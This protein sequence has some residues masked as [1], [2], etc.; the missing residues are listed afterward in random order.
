MFMLLGLVLG[1]C[2]KKKGGGGRKSKTP[3]KSYDPWNGVRPSLPENPV[4]GL[5]LLGFSDGVAISYDEREASGEEEICRRET[6]D[7]EMLEVCIP[8]EDDPY[9]V[10]LE[11][12]AFVWH[13]LMFERFATDLSCYAYGE[14]EARSEEDCLLVVFP[15]MGGEDFSCEAG[16]VNGDRALKCS[17]DWAV[18]ANGHESD[19]KSICRAHLQTGVGICL[20]APK[21]GFSDGELILQMQRSNWDGYR[22]G[23]D[24]N[25]QFMAGDS[26]QALIPQE[27]PGGA[28]VSY[29][30]DNDEICTVDNDDEDGGKGSV[31]IDASVTPPEVCKIYLLIEA[32]GFADWVLFVELPILDESDVQWPN[33]VRSNNYFYPG[34]SLDAEPV[35]STAT[36]DLENE[37]ISL[38]EG[39]CSVDEN[40]TIT[41]LAPG[42]CV[43]RLTVKAQ[44][45]LDVVID[46]TTPVDALT[47][48]IIDIVWDSFDALDAATAV[49]GADIPALTVPVAKE[50]GGVDASGATLSYDVSGGCAYD[51]STRILSFSDVTECVITVTA[52]SGVRSEADFSKDFAFTPGPALFTLTWAG[53]AGGNSAQY[54][55]A[56]PALEPPVTDPVSL[57][58]EYSYTASGGGC[59]VDGVSGALTIVGATTCEVTLTASKE[60]YGD[61]TQSHT[62]TIDKKA[63]AD[64]TFNAPYAGALNVAVGSTPVRVL[65]PPTG[66]VGNLE[67]KTLNT[68]DCDIESDGTVSATAAATAGN[69]CDIQARWSGDANHDESSWVT[70]ATITISSADQDQ[71]TWGA[72]PY[73][74]IPVVEVDDDLDINSAPS[75]S[76]GDPAYRSDTPGICTVDPVSGTVT[77]VIVGECLV[78][79]RFTGNTANAASPWS[80][81]ITIPVDPGVH[82]ALS[83]SNYY[84]DNPEVAIARNLALTTTPEGHGVAT[85]SVKNGSETYCSVEASSGT[86][87]GLALGSCTIQVSFA[88]STN[89]NAS[90]AMD[91]GTINVLEREQTITINNPYGTSATMAVEET[92]ELVNAPTAVIQDNNGNSIEGGAIT[93]QV[94]TASAG[95]CSVA[96][97]GVITALAPGECAIQ[98]EVAAVTADANKPTY[99][100]ATRDLA[101]IAVEMGTFSFTWSPQLPGVDYRTGMESKIARVDIGSTGAQV[102]YAVVDAG[103]TGCDFKGN[104]GED[105]VTLSF[106]GYGVCTLSATA[107]KQHYEDWSMERIIRVRPG[108]I[109]ATPGAFV[110]SDTL[111]VGVTQPKVP[112][113][114]TGL[115]PSDAEASWQLVRGEKDCVLVNEQTGAVVAR[116]VPIPD[117]ANPPQCS[118]QVVASKE[119]YD[120]FKSEPVSIDL[121]RGDMGSLTAPEYGLGV[122]ATL[123]ING[124]VAIFK[125][126]AE[127][128]GLPVVPIAFAATGTQSD[129]TTDKSDVCDVQSDG[130]V[131]AGS[132]AAAGDQCKIVITMEAPGYEPA[133]APEAVLTVVDG[134]FAFETAPVVSFVG[135]LK[136]G[137]ET[138]ASDSGDSSGV[139]YLDLSGIPEEYVPTDDEGNPQTAVPLTWHYRARSLDAHGDEDE[140]SLCEIEA[141]NGKIHLDVESSARVGGHCLVKAIAQVSGYAEYAT[142]ELAIPFAP[143]DLVIT[144][145]DLYAGATLRVG[146]VAAASDETDDDNGVSVTWGSWRAVGTDSGSAEK[147]DV[148]SVDGEGLVQAGSAAAA[149]DVCTVY[150][151][152]GAN[153]YNNS[154]ELEVGSLTLVARMALG[155]VTGPVYNKDL[156]VRGV[157]VEFD[158]APRISGA[159]ADE[160]IHWTYEATGKRAG[161]ATADICSVDEEGAVLPGSDATGGDTC[162]IVATA[163][164]PGYESKAA[165]V[166]SL[167]VKDTFTSLTW[168]NFPTEGVVGTDIN[169]ADNQPVSDPVGALAIS[170]TSDDCDYNSGS[171]VLSFSDASECVVEV[172]AS[173][174]GYVD[175]TETY[176]VTPSSGSIAVSDW[177]TYTGVKVGV[178]IAAPGLTN[179]NPS[180]AEKS[181]ALAGGSAGCT[182]DSA[183]AV[184]GTTVGS[185]A[186]QVILTL[187]NTGY[188]NLEHTYSI[189]V[190]KGD[191]D[192]PSFAADPYGASPNVEPD[193]TLALNVSKPSGQGTLEFSVKSS[194][195]GNCTVDATSGEISGADA[196]AGS[197]CTI[198]AQFLTN[199]DYNAS[200]L[201]DV[202]TV[203]VNKHD[204]TFPA[205][206]NPYGASPEVA[207]GETETISAALPS[208]QGAL[209][210]QILSGHATYCSVDLTS[211]EVTPKAAG[212][213][214][215][216]SVQARFVGNSAHEATAWSTIA[217]ISVINGTITAS[218]S[219]YGTVKVAA[220]TSAPGVTS[221]PVGAARAWSL[222]SGS[223]G[224]TLGS[225][226]AVTGDAV[227]TD[228]CKVK[229]IL[230]ENGYDNLEHVYTFSIAKGDQ[231][232]VSAVQISGWSNPY[233]TSLELRT[234]GSH[235]LPA[236]TG[237]NSGI[238][239]LGGATLEYQKKPSSVSDCTVAQDGTVTAGTSEGSCIV[240][241]R[242]RES[243]Q[244]NASPNWQDLE[245]I[246][247]AAQ[248][249]TTTPAWSGLFAVI[250]RE[251]GDS[252]STAR[253]PGSYEVGVPAATWVWSS[254]DP[255]V[256][257]VNPS[258]GEDIT[259]LRTG[260]C[261]ITGTPSKAGYQAVGPFTGTFTITEGTQAAPTWGTSPYP[262]GSTVPQ[263]KI[264][265]TLPIG[266]VTPTN[267]ESD[268][269]IVEYERFGGS[270]SICTV[271]SSTG[272]VTAGTTTGNCVVRARL[273]A[274]ANKWNQSSFSNVVTVRVVLRTL[275][276]S[277]T[278]A[279]PGYIFSS[280]TGYIAG[281][282]GTT[283]ALNPTP[284]N[285]DGYLDDNDVSINAVF[286]AVGTDNDGS[287][288]ANVCSVDSSGT[289]TIGSAGTSGD[290]CVVSVSYQADTYADLDAGVLATFHLGAAQ[291]AI[292]TH[293]TGQYSSSSVAVG[294]TLERTGDPIPGGGQEA[295]DNGL[296][297]YRTNDVKICTVVHE[298]YNQGNITGVAAG[299]CQIQVRWRGK[300]GK[301]ASPWAN[302]G[303]AIT[304]T[305]AP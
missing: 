198:Q 165:A 258:D 232:D 178:A 235:S 157:P 138:D 66:G 76:M 200:P 70:I 182:V 299:S 218:W 199:T 130:L 136:V 75:G 184:T 78:Q 49:V 27:L 12:N 101:T 74:A 126:P 231:Q 63:Q 167:N 298:S 50:A 40:G 148:C 28:K 71:P 147:A 177:G 45:Y 237:G 121:E 18:V 215:N 4:D 21:E 14:G 155:S 8:L 30:S 262:Y 11:S 144:S 29:F 131:V 221:V 122:A 141:R 247:I 266:N 249:W 84:G 291:S 254:N 230:S 186:C 281:V 203:S 88:A 153:S 210:Y 274:V 102:V 243:T 10:V 43:I 36:S 251:Y 20:A 87:T 272:E 112:S 118:V 192:P 39:V 54:D 197:D 46:R 190:A 38:S 85:Y 173:L 94:T 108:L 26:A 278:S 79:F 304:V 293:L 225:N 93:Y 35:N 133:D 289:V 51:S 238:T 150:A 124:S 67:Y 214:N 65:N 202:A 13:P 125:A 236:P 220:E 244:Y 268:G 252:A 245:T 305:P 135:D 195:N 211:G 137:A 123:P 264:G 146:G 77:G 191:Q 204:Q 246:T 132:A 83:G 255:S 212:A 98:I 58:A 164:A 7:G 41:A 60:G 64:P 31:S 277:S 284:A 302:L 97:D 95:V 180:S 206:A 273:G 143:G 183:G 25:R 52:S 110:N 296:L 34:E 271:N 37:Y 42:E 59:E 176:R 129:G 248:E 259:V 47:E 3:T 194:T 119:Q 73:G 290:T 209:N 276:V 282:Q 288:N 169:L 56:A 115:N 207:V 23:H 239:G 44:G 61:Q 100:G 62:V 172:T 33:Y 159:G 90:D 303:A 86:V 68:T 15:A 103:D 213:G 228:N 57:G 205:W 160:D 168:V 219:S 48:K 111:K 1:A 279:L 142:Q 224:C 196:G 105:A 2:S 139:N 283:E 261:S 240:Q 270:D 222:D 151:V 253:T 257:T 120:T 241:V 92:R 170:A 227:G 301:G 297:Q 267:R 292:T 193:G 156:E 22:S 181:Y 106:D 5:R 189:D 229:L 82:P 275:S 109:T 295:I 201:M 24:N 269:G 16:L 127:Q 285:V 128:N 53:Y 233:G 162:E 17:D 234:D 117:E 223:A 81:S 217:T 265:D 256:C 216:C 89:Y 104:L 6:E 158:T 175:R 260:T 287:D 145:V 263:V 154:E 174:V 187:T 96:S 9:F 226:G 161:A 91:I 188:D 80:D 113:S 134:A 140:I 185:D 171:N 179:L 19:T 280:D 149:G 163:H 32:K 114:Y 286:S 55:S 72:D 99:R 294:S 208:G 152:A 166:V 107:T 116:A 69:T 300:A 242:F 250:T